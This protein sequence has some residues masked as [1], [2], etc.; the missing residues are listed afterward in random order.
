MSAAEILDQIKAL[1]AEERMELLEKLLERRA[2][3]VPN[4]LRQSMAEA[5]RGELI[6][7]DDALQDT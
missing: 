3:D 6:D 7:T 1:T 2:A 4:S 5:E